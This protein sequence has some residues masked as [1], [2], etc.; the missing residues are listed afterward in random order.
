MDMLVKYSRTM[1]ETPFAQPMVV[2]VALP[3]LTTNKHSSLL[4]GSHMSGLRIKLS[5]MVRVFR[6]QTN[7]LQVQQVFGTYVFQGV[8]Y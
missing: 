3:L 1:E 8:P 7:G 2:P 4:F 5:V 6:Q